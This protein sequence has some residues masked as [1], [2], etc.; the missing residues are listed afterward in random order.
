[1][2]TVSAA[3]EPSVSS[4]CNDCPSLWRSP[5]YRVPRRR[6]ACARAAQGRTGVAPVVLS[7]PLEDLQPALGQSIADGAADAPVFRWLGE[8]V[9]WSGEAVPFIASYNEAR[10]PCLPSRVDPPTLP[11]RSSQVL[12]ELGCSSKARFFGA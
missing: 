11:H 4:Q 3:T 5:T 1:M 10:P 8:T 7:H 9:V 2:R 6:E 12:N